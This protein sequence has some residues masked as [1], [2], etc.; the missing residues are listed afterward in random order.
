[1]DSIRTFNH[2]QKTFLPILTGL[3]NDMDLHENKRDDFSEWVEKAFCRSVTLWCTPEPDERYEENLAE[4]LAYNFDCDDH[5][6]PFIQAIRKARILAQKA[7]L[8]AP[9]RIVNDFAEA[10][11]FMTAFAQDVTRLSV[12]FG[13]DSGDSQKHYVV[14]KLPYT[15]RIDFFFGKEDYYGPNNLTIGDDMKYLGFFDKES[16]KLYDLR[17]PMTVCWFHRPHGDVIPESGDELKKAVTKTLQNEVA[18]RVAKSVPELP[19]MPPPGD[20]VELLQDVE[21]DYTDGISVADFADRVK[22]THYYIRTNDIIHFITEPEALIAER[23]DDYMKWHGAKM[24]R[25]WIA[26]LAEEKI[27]SYTAALGEAAKGGRQNG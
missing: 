27:L 4:K 7:I 20:L 8:D 14:Y 17:E 1:M 2:F 24:E 15:D 11:D 16:G 3:L 12:M 6:E 22:D 21:A 10:A 18:R 19:D 26:Y 9:Y 13:V 23:A 5:M 25:R